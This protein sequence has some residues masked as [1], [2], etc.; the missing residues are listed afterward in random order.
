MALDSRQKRAAV[1][2]VARPWY[3]NP[4][5][6][7]M[8][9]NQRASVGQVY[10]VALFTQPAPVFT[11]T[12]DNISEIYDSGSYMYDFTAYF[13]FATSYAISPDLESGWSFAAG[14]LT[15]DTDG[16]GNFGPFTVTG[17]NSSGQTDSNIFTIQV[18]VTTPIPI[19]V[20]RSGK[21]TGQNRSFSAKGTNRVISFTNKNRL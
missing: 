3:R 18:A 7:G 17:I 19:G 9:A 11:G 6:S 1:A 2:G 5:P 8:N 4:H 10:P 16:L 13:T 14:V 21:S 15:I 20:Q 12:I